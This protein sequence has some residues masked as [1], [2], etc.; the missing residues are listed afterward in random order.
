MIGA[1]AAAFGSVHANVIKAG[2][3]CTKAEVGK[4][5]KVGKTPYICMVV[6]KK[7]KWEVRH[8]ISLR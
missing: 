6:G 7:Y 4:T 2:S 8:V 3:K 1:P 5:T